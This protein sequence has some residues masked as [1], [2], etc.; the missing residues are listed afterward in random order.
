MSHIN[1][2]HAVRSGRVPRWTEHFNYEIIKI[3]NNNSHRTLLE[4][5]FIHS[6]HHT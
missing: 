5:C 3:F 1:N 2:W 4:T 6:S